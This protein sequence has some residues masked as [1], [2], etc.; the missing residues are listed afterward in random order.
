MAKI[1][2]NR[3]T[4]KRTTLRNFVRL[5]DR[6]VELFLALLGLRLVFAALLLILVV[7]LAI[8]FLV[9]LVAMR[10]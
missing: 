5:D 10:S 9:F 3:I 7:V 4:Q 6:R 1:I 2:L 8:F